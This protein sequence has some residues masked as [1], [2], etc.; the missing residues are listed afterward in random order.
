MLPERIEIEIE[1]MADGQPVAG[2][3]ADVSLSMTSKNP[4]T[5]VLGPSD[6]RGRIVAKG[7]EL[8]EMAAQNCRN[9][10]MDYADLRQYFGGVVEVRLATR[11]RVLEMQKAY[12]SFSSAFEYPADWPMVLKTAESWFAQNEAKSL[13]ARVL[14]TPSEIRVNALEATP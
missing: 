13:T 8:L 10:V 12:E 7:P 6:G 11:D 9:F 4:H 14:V 5:M 2:A 1:I 3:L